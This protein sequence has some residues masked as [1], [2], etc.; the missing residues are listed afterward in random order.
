ME[1]PMMDPLQMLS[2]NGKVPYAVCY[3]YVDS[4]FLEVLRDFSANTDTE[5][6]AT[7]WPEYRST[8]LLSL[9]CNN[10]TLL[11]L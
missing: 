9:Q 8:N 11:L 10:M 1:Q 5:P 4:H 6:A 2:H 3:A 7:V